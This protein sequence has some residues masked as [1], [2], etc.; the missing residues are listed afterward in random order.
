MSTQLVTRGVVLPDIDIHQVQRMLPHR[1]PFLLVDRVINLLAFESATGIKCV[2]VN[3]P[4]FQG[5]FPNDPIMPGVL[6]VE[7]MGQTAALLT[8]ASNGAFDGGIGIFL[9]GFE[10]GRFRAPVRPGHQLMIDVR[11]IG[12]KLGIV[13]YE[14]VARI[15]ER[16]ASQASFSVKIA[17]R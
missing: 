9:T 17:K 13:K 16:I 10:H 11:Q 14:A 8:M 4:Y 15:D 5:H 12:Q 7:A 6:Q 2:T 3:E 1:Y